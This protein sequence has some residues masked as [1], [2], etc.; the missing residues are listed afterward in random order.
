MVVVSEQPVVMMYSRRRC[1][2]CDQARAVI[3]AEL[4][5]GAFSFREIFIDGDDGLEQEYG[6][7]VPVV[8]VNAVEEF[9]FVVDPERLRALMRG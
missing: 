4:D 9:E 5:R 2:L 8:E 6:L 7:R 3:E 1:G